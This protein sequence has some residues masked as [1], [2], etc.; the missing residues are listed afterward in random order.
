M[1]TRLA[2]CLQPLAETEVLLDPGEVWQGIQTNE[3]VSKVR[4]NSWLE[5]WLLT[6]ESWQGPLWHHRGWFCRT[7]QQAPKEKQIKWGVL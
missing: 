4:A 5:V 7:M 6:W 1:A 3:M 2:L